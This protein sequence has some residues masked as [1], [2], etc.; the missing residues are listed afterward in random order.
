MALM[1]PLLIIPKRTCTD[2]LPAGS[3]HCS[4]MRGP[5]CLMLP[6]TKSVLT[7]NF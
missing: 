4:L 5:A 7:V 6:L 3:A 2:L 1:D